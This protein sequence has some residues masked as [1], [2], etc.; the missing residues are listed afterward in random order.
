MSQIHRLTL[1]RA[2]E[3]NTALLAAYRRLNPEH[4][5]RTHHFHGRFENTYIPLAQIPELQPVVNAGLGFAQN[6]LGRQPLRYGFWFN[7]MGP[8]HVTS[9]HN[10]EEDDE[11]LSGCYYIRVPAKSGRFLAEME[12]GEVPIQPKEGLFL[13]FSPSLMHAVEENLSEETRLS[14]A[15]NFGRAEEA[16]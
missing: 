1:D 5:R 8:G 2:A 9:R 10:H 11:L 4:L 14:V 12:E 13:F 6:L 3:V 15:F 16:D 7:E